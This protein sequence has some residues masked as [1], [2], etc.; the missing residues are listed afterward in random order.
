MMKTSKKILKL[1]KNILDVDKMNLYHSNYPKYKKK[2]QSVPLKVQY[3]D[4]KNTCFSIT[5]L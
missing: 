5:F 1:R 4:F 2:K 3:G